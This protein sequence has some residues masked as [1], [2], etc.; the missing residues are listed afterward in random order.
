MRNIASEHNEQRVPVTAGPLP[1]TGELRDPDHKTR[2]EPHFI[3]PDPL[4]V[5]ADGLRELLRQRPHP[6]EAADNGLDQQARDEIDP[7]HA[8][9]LPEHP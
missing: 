1:E 5:P 6:A 4:H 7:G 8:Q 9:N 2:P 3:V